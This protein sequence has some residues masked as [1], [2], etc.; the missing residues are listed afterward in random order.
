[1]LMTRSSHLQHKILRLTHQC[2]THDVF[3]ELAR[4]AAGG[5]QSR[6]NRIY[7]TARHCALQLD[8]LGCKSRC[9]GTA[10]GHGGVQQ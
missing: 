4:L 10:Q 5:E 9:V 3:I 8:P 7:V 2:D 1:M 6:K